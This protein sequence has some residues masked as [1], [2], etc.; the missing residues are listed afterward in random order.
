MTNPFSGTLIIKAPGRRVRLREGVHFKNFRA[1]YPTLI[2]DGN[3]EVDL[4]T[5]GG[6]LEGIVGA[7]VDLLFMLDGQ[8]HPKLIEGLV[9][10]KGNLEMRKYAHFKGAV[11]C[12]GSADIRETNKIVHDPAIWAIPPVG[13]TLPNARMAIMPGTWQ[14]VTLP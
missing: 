11:I 13:Y 10:V 14:Q 2:V 3:L 12:E 8:E 4:E 7:L 1:D 9:H 6:I 5:S